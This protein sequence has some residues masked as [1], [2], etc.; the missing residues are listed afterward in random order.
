MFMSTYLGAIWGIWSQIWGN[1]E[2]EQ[3]KKRGGGCHKLTPGEA[4]SATGQPQS[5][6]STPCFS[7]Y[8]SV[9]CISIRSL[10]L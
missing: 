7:G 5:H 10:K 4:E 6:A 2:A 3:T 1:Y 9:T 8:S